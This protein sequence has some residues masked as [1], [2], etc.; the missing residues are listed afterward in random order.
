MYYVRVA[1]GAAGM[2]SAFN[3]SA[4]NRNP[5]IATTN[6]VVSRIKPLCI[7]TKNVQE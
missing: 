6:N 3:S 5:S 1:G 4:S 7:Q 2:A